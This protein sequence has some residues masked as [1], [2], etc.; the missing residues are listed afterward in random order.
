MG[1]DASF[2]VRELPLP[3]D[4]LLV[5]RPVEESDIEG[6]ATLYESLGEDD[7]Y[8]R[9]FQCHTPPRTTT[10]KMVS[11]TGRGGFRLVA[12]ILD[13][14]G[15]RRLVGE[16]GYEP[17]PN[18]DGELA[19]TIDRQARGWLGP[20][21]LDAVM[22]VASNLGV[23]NLE[24]DVLMENRRMLALV[25]SRGY[26]TMDHSTCPGTVRVI[27]GTSRRVP[28]FPKRG[29]RPRVLVE[30]EGGR[31]HRES[32]ARAAGLGV[33]VCPG[34][35]SR[36]SHC[37]ALRGRPCPLAQDADV[38]VDTICSD[39]KEADALREAHEALHRAV[40]LCLE[41]SSQRDQPGS[42]RE[43][44][45]DADDASVFELLRSL[46]AHD[47]VTAAEGRSL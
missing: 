16:C 13:R 29:A 40:P 25:R 2:L 18:G 23:E 14:S 24:A 19:I 32:A 17:L 7:L 4:R 42:D 31:W 21:M 28:T 43:V 26:A 15:S 35:L 11:A 46:A 1:T 27:M 36:R 47:A 44:T 39:S 10:Q 41:V 45:H 9:F 6:I 8:F 37:P 33:L 34:P 30:A 20:Y 5:V 12:E 3:G 22:G 38:I